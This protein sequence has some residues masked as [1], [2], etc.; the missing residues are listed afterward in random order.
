MIIALKSYFLVKFVS[1]LLKDIVNI[2]QLML[3]GL[4]GNQ[5]DKLESIKNK[6][7]TTLP[8]CIR[9]QLKWKKIAHH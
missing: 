6:E 1:L 2:I 9:K 5:I 7:T 3:V 8:D 4:T